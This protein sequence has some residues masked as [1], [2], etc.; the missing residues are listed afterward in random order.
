M[1]KINLS[2]VNRLYTV[3]LLKTGDRH[4]YELMDRIEEI[5][6]KRPS[7]SH[8][9]PFLSKLKEKGLLEEEKDGRKKVYSLTEKGDKFA[10]EKLDSFGEVIEAAVL[11]NIQE[12]ASCG[13]EIYSGGYE[14]EGKT[15]CCEHCAKAH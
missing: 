14:E 6:G 9:Y 4:G 1:S 11:D 3:L 15:F 10:S 12:C 2:N 5:T 13:C 7:S 8:I